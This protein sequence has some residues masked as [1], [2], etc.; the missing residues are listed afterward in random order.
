MGLEIICSNFWNRPTEA[1]KNSTE[2]VMFLYLFRGYY[3]TA[4]FGNFEIDK[5]DTNKYPQ[6]S[7]PTPC[8]IRI[9]DWF[10]REG[11]C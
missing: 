10:L 1:S 2:F 4:H 8:F 5:R 7:I 3:I 9:Y 11:I 6:P